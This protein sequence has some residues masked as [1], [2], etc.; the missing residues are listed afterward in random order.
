MRRFSLQTVLVF[1]VCLVLLMTTQALSEVSP[2]DVLDKTNWEKAEGLVPDE[3]LG[4]IKK[5]DFVLQVGE[6]SYKACDYQP[7]YALQASTDNMGR[8]GL[9]EDDWIVEK[10]TGRRVEQMIGH[11]F[12]VIDWD[13][14]KVAEMIMYNRNYTQYIGGNVLAPFSTDY[15]KSSGYGRSTK[16]LMHNL[17]MDGNPESLARR[18]PDRVEKYQIFLARSPYDIAGTA[19][20]TWRYFDPQKQD[21]TFAF[22]P[23]IRRVRRMSSGNRSD[24]LFGS[25]FSVDDAGGYDGKVTAMEWKF[26]RKQEALVP[27]PSSTPARIVEGEEGGWQSSE[28]TEEMIY[29]YQKEGW[30]GASWA[31]VNWIWVKQPVYVLETKAK[32][33]YYSYGIQHI[34]VY[35]ETWNIVYKTVNDKAG[36]YWKTFMGQPRHFESEDKAFRLTYIGDQIV[37]DERSEHATLITGPSP[38]DIWNYLAEMD[39]NDFSL[40]GF[41]KFCK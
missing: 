27:F 24:A 19:V 37:I 6:L 41:Q 23:A 16:G 7:P 30:Q 32:D 5:G 12:P 35:A 36:K 8:Y 10:E 1:A 40:A 39:E 31:P 38:K 11:P 25:D 20:M 22:V 15:V 34:W 29:G 13:D 4:W 17:V 21:N 28:N 14:P 9:D 3:L 33:P 26:L 2:G 18:N